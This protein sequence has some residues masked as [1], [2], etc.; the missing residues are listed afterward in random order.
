MLCLIGNSELID[1]VIQRGM[2]FFNKIWEVYIY[3]G[4]VVIINYRFRVICDKNYYGISCIKFCRFRNDI[5]GYYICNEN[6]NKV[7]MVGWRGKFC[8][9]GQ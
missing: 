4:F 9:I 3:N 1:R 6:G 2:I 5:F 7:C 8:D